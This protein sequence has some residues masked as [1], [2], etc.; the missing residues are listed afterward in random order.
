MAD[1]TP[2]S[3]LPL[4]D[5]DIVQRTMTAAVERI[6]NRR[7]AYIGIAV[8]AIVA[9]IAVFVFVN[10]PDGDPAAGFHRMWGYAEKVRDEY[11]RDRSA[12][13]QLAELEGYVADIKGN[14]EE[15]LGLWLLGIYCYREAWTVDKT[16]FDQRQP[17][18]AKAVSYLE[19]LQDETFD[20]LLLAKPRW[21]TN[22]GEA[23]VDTVLQ[24]VRADLEWG[25][26]HA[27]ATPEPED[28]PVAVLRTSAGDIHLRFFGE[29][30]PAHVKN[31][32]TLARKGTY[33]GTAFHFLRGG[34]DDPVGA[35]A[36]DPFTFFYPDAQ[37][38]EHLLRWGKGGVGYDIPAE[39]ARYRIVH[40]KGIVTSQRVEKADWDNGVQFQIMLNL[41]R[42]LD[43]IHTPFAK[44]VEGLDVL[45]QIEKCKTVADHD[46][47][48]DDKEFRSLFT[49]DLIVE[50]VVIHKVIV[51]ENGKALEH[52]FPLVD[53]EKTINTLPTTKVVAL[54][55]DV[56]YGGRLLRAPSADGEARKGLDI[57]F[58]SDADVAK[59]SPKGERK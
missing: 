31:F 1:K 3:N 20:D 43:R 12:R 49:R 59:D 16:S 32:I 48:R 56:I 58:P 28:S 38:K 14:P 6:Q 22:G 8:L 11:N 50:P 37:K 25:K 36:G 51:Y 19:Q 17:Y 42:S 55:E 13:E 46:T 34:R 52:D 39:P 9:I 30:A 41:D 44:V 40:Q 21:F 10:M 24:Q 35:M 23:P 27:K 5:P 7:W 18:L 54:D 33:N 15:G 47:F 4:P 26:Q 2:D 57:P 45:T 53:G 29:L